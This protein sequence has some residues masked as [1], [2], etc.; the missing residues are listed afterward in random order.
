LTSCRELSFRP[1]SFCPS[2]SS[3]CFA[4]PE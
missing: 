1:S 3:S 4:L 2:A